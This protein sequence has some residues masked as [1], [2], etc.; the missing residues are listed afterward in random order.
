MAEMY[1]EAGRILT[2][3]ETRRCG[4]RAALYE[5]GRGEKHNPLIPKVCALVCRTLERKQ[6]LERLLL[7][8]G[9]LTSS[10]GGGPSEVAPASSRDGGGG[11][12]AAQREDEDADS[13]SPDP[14]FLD[15]HRGVI[16]AMAFDFLFGR[17][18][19]LGGGQCRRLVVSRLQAAKQNGAEMRKDADPRETPASERIQR[20]RETAEARAPP[21]KRKTRPDTAAETIHK[22]TKSRARQD[23]EEEEKGEEE[24]GEEE[25]GEEGE[26]GRDRGRPESTSLMTS[27]E[28][29]PRYL[30]VALSRV[31]LEEAQES[32]ASS[33]ASLSPRTPAEVALDPLLPRC[34]LRASPAAARFLLRHP[35]VLTGC[36][37]LQ[38]RA[39]ALAAVA[40]EIGPGDVV[41]DACAAPGSKTLHALDRLQGRGH[42][43]AL[44][45][46][47]KRAATLI[48]RLRL[49]GNLDGP[50]SDPSCSPTSRIPSAGSG[51]SR[52]TD[53]WRGTVSDEKKETRKSRPDDGLPSQSDCATYA[54]YAARRPLYFTNAVNT[55]SSSPSSSSP[56]SSSLASSSP[57]SESSASVLRDSKARSALLVEVRVTDFLSV[58]GSKPPFCFVEKML[59]D[60][61]CSGSGL[62]LHISSAAHST[63]SLGETSEDLSPA[64]SSSSSSSSLASFSPSC[65]GF[66]PLPPLARLSPL[67]PPS[68]SLARVRQLARFQRTL[69]SHAL[70]TFPKLLLCCY[71]T[72]SSYVEEN[73]AVLAHVLGQSGDAAAEE[74]GKGCG[75]WRLRR[76]REIDSRWHPSCNLL[77]LMATKLEEEQTAREERVA[78]GNNV[79][80]SETSGKVGR[81]T[82][83]PRKMPSRDE[84]NRE[85]ETVTWKRALA[86]F[87]PACIRSSPATHFCRG[88]FLARLER[89]TA[90]ADR[91][92]PA[93]E[94]DVNGSPGTRFS[95]NATVA[96]LGSNGDNRDRASRRETQSSV[97]R[98]LRKKSAR[99]HV[100]FQKRRL[101]K[102]VIV[103]MQP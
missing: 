5:N 90:D 101:K 62:P 71:S 32:L 97:Q 12:L 49:H 103:G 93:S 58:S 72:C 51:S 96:G 88:F 95:D 100:A 80:L 52:A 23:K 79:R 70:S 44:E 6:E 84:A 94:Q 38:D 76:G 55:H 9:L 66:C 48:R 75:R 1:I 86:T 67:S 53:A 21:Q 89:E 24:E 8:A 56:S 43:I 2:A 69:L 99:S 36:V 28:R 14:N 59:L 26:A 42:L 13:E 20:L 78:G 65:E 82:Q 16:L 68:A 60:P 77:K 40:A 15:A 47:V 92:V 19:V 34:G 63:S 18:K 30:R 81:A 39:S 74:A 87:G 10:S 31:S 91:R 85:T 61:S 102:G 64:S 7:S 4:L 46:D 29:F 17:G 57:S 35:L 54:R 73:E 45:R 83:E 98:H 41:L 3:M 37:A 25:E 27:D 50:F 22:R 33:L 11:A